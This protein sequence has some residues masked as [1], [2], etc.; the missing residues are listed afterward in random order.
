MAWGF[1][2]AICG[3]PFHNGGLIPPEGH[4][5]PEDSDILDAIR[6]RKVDEWYDEED[7]CDN[8]VLDKQSVAWLRDLRAIGKTKHK[9]F[10]TGTGFESERPSGEVTVDPGDDE[11]VPMAHELLHQD[12]PGKLRLDLYYTES[13]PL[14][15]TSY[16]VHVKC[17]DLLQQAHKQRSYSSGR[18]HAKLDLNSLYKAMR[19][20]EVLYKT[21]LN[22]NGYAE[23]REGLGQWW[24]GPCE[25]LEVNAK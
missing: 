6:L 4:R 1:F 2:C 15:H 25:S 9:A 8:T 7:Y 24:E 22:L 14:C 13:S 20:C 18:E 11:N 19:S 12:Q 5:Y 23:F 3:G 17:F 10:I 21:H 16:P